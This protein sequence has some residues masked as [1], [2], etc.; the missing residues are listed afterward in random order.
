MRQFA[1]NVDTT[2]YIIPKG[3]GGFVDKFFGATTHLDPKVH[4]FL[5]KHNEVMIV[6]INRMMTMVNELLTA[7]QG[8]SMV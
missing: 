5:D 7:A 3:E 2:D 8:E 4:Q 1:V 6:I